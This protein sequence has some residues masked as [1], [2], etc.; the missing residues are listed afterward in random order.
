MCSTSFWRNTTTNSGILLTGKIITEQNTIDVTGDYFR[1]KTERT[2]EEIPRYSAVLERFI[3]NEIITLAEF[4]QEFEVELRQSEAFSTT[5]AGEKRWS[6]LKSR[7]VEHNIRMM[8]K[9]YTKIRLTRMSKLLALTET[10]TEDCL[11]DMVVAGTVSAK[12]D[13]LEGIV[14]FTEQEVGIV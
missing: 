10:E 9:Y 7:I 1:I 5:E 6:D 12:T 3:N 2:L 14:D 8:A 11:S 13:R 4:C